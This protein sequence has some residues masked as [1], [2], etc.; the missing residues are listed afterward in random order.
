MYVVSVNTG[1]N[2]YYVATGNGL[3]QQ[4]GRPGLFRN[5]LLRKGDH[6]QLDASF[7]R[8]ARAEHA[9]DAA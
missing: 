8:I 2:S 6:L 3:A 1:T 4:I 7:E 5:T 9:L